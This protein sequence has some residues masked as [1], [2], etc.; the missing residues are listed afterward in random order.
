MNDVSSMDFMIFFSSLI[1]GSLHLIL[2]SF[3]T[4]SIVLSIPG[5]VNLDSVIKTFLY[6][7][8]GDHFLVTFLTF[9]VF[10]SV[11]ELNKNFRLVLFPQLLCI[12]SL[13]VDAF[14][15]LGHRS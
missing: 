6:G 13:G 12:L 2:L 15:F 4:L 1:Y 3:D 14:T 10:F 5:S 8:P 9:H 7:Y 11:R